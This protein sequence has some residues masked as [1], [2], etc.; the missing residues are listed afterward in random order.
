MRS[1]D[2]RRDASDARE[3]R[4]ALAAAFRS[5]G[6]SQAHKFKNRWTGAPN[7]AFPDALR[8]LDELSAKWFEPRE[9]EPGCFAKGGVLNLSARQKKRIDGGR[10]DAEDEKSC[11][12]LCGILEAP[13]NTV[14]REIQQSQ[15]V[16]FMKSLHYERYLEK[17]F[18]TPT[19]RRSIVMRN[20]PTVQSSGA[21]AIS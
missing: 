13:M 6:R 2:S 7:D 11:D 16:P 5:P 17:S 1:S 15:L 18:P 21:C 3:R 19:V 4:W 20:A 10:K 8:D 12:M 9:I 14:Y